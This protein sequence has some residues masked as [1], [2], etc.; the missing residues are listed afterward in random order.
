MSRRR[1]LTVVA[2]AA[3][4]PAVAGCGAGIRR[5]GGAGHPRPFFGLDE[6]QAA[7]SRLDAVS[8]QLGYRPSV[9]S[10]FVKLDTTTLRLRLAAMQAAHETPFVTL[11]PWLSAMAS[12]DVDEPAYALRTIADGAHDTEL[13]RLAHQMTT[14][15][16][17]IYLRFAHEMNAWWYP[18]AASVNANSPAEYV[19]AWRHVHDLFTGVRGLD[20]RWVWAPATVVGSRS[21]LDLASLYPGDRYVDDIGLSGYGHGSP[22]PARTYDPLLAELRHV[23]A[24]PVILS[25]IGADGHGKVAWLAGLGS[26]LVQHPSIVGFVYFD[27]SPVSTG[28][29][30]DYAFSSSP[31]TLGALRSTLPPLA[32]PAVSAPTGRWSVGDR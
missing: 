15:H 12:G 21:T 20:L 9:F 14:Y 11:E 30:G 16:G 32:G 1:L 10:V 17:V 24:K 27:T 19:A 28:A 4:V 26:W 31:S 29:T 7:I 5:A 23:S 25:E 8:A 6:P 2:G 22:S 13:L 18:W 3:L